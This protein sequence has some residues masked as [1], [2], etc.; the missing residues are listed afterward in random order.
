MMP[1]P[2]NLKPKIA[3]DASS[4]NVAASASKELTPRPYTLSGQ[5]DTA[6]LARCPREA[7]LQDSLGD[8]LEKQIETSARNKRLTYPSPKLPNSKDLQN[9]CISFIY[10]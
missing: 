2:W 5:A 7:S 10:P 3:T 9:A 6:V 4:S 1:L 8:P